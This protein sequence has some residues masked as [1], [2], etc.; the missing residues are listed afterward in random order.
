MNIFQSDGPNIQT[1]YIHNRAH[2]LEHVYA[3]HRVR[4]PTCR[5]LYILYIFMLVYMVVISC[6]VFTK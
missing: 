3:A 2:V 6:V 4:V 5:Y 1:R